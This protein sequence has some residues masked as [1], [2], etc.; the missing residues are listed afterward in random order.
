MPRLSLWK[1]SK[2]SNDYKFIDRRISEMFTVGGTGILLHKYL[3]PNDQSVLK[4]TISSQPSA[5]TNLTVTDTT[6]LEIGMFVVGANIVENTK[7]SAITGTTIRL[8]QSTTAAV[9]SG[10]SIKFH[11]DATKPGYA[12]DSILNL[13]DLLFLENRDRKYDTSVYVMRGI[14]QVQ[15]NSFDLSQFGLFLQTGTLFMVFHLNDMVAALGRKIMNGDVLELQHLTDYH[16]LDESLPVALKRFFVVSDCQFAS[17]G[18]SPTWWPHL[19]RIK[20]NPMTDSQEYKDILN[21]IKTDPL[22]ANSAPIGDY[23]STLN[24]YLDINDSIIKQA[25]VDVPNSGYNTSVLYTK[26]VMPDGRPADPPNVDTTDAGNLTADTTTTSADQ[27]ALTSA[28]KI[29]AYMGGDGTAPNGLPVG[30]GI[31]F[32]GNPNIGDYFLRLDY[33]PNRLFRFDGSRWNKVEDVNRT[34]LTPGS[35]NQTQLG[36]YVNNDRTWTDASGQTRKERTSLSQALK[37]KADN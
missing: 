2:H 15:D 37:P 16:A 25:E 12:T 18:F 17:E 31:S 11:S 26:G 3:G 22:D 7:I 13:Q 1:D 9:T 21:N 36:T 5:G 30:N 6:N 28:E 27:M 14:Y 24:K 34:G 35:G 33:L 23:L 32:P 29:P 19:W 10:A 20:L 8:S 4:V